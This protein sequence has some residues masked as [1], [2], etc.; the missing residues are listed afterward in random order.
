M[1]FALALSLLG[2]VHDN[3]TPGRNYPWH[4]FD[5][6][7][8]AARVDVNS[9]GQ[10]VGGPYPVAGVW[11]NMVIIDDESSGGHTHGNDSD[12]RPPQ[13]PALALLGP[14]TLQPGET[15]TRRVTGPDGQA[16][17]SWQEDGFAGNVTTLLVPEDINWRVEQFHAVLEY[18][19]KVPNGSVWK[20]RNLM[21]MSDYGETLAFQRHGDTRHLD[22]FN[23]LP[24]NSRWGTKSNLTQVD[25]ITRYYRAMSPTGAKLDLTRIS[26]KSGG[27]GDNKFLA[28][29]TTAY[30]YLTWAYKGCNSAGVEFD[31]ENP[32]LDNGGVGTPAGDSAYGLFI[33]VMNNA[34]K[35]RT[36]QVLDDGVTPIPRD[37]VQVPGYFPGAPP[38]TVFKIWHD[39]AIVKVVCT[40]D[41]K[42]DRLN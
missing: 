3:P 31:I 2:E 27:C 26:L 30:Q 5:Y 24:G 25:Q 12:S 28:G 29:G 17:F 1:F 18:F 23:N 7:Y 38:L 35:C 14:Q 22:S 8:L 20:A 36:S 15:L 4:G 41:P 11:V 6:T 10:V 19:E 42:K 40:I 13:T 9:L 34:F 37:T 32:A 33:Q 21:Q 16:H 39:A